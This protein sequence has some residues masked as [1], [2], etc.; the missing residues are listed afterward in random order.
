ML[1]KLAYGIVYPFVFD[2]YQLLLMAFLFHHAR[3]QLHGEY[4]LMYQVARAVKYHLL[5]FHNV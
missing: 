3:H 2:D 4:R 1:M 5:N